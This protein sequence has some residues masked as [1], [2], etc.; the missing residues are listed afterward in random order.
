MS[1]EDNVEPRKVRRLVLLTG[2]FESQLLMP[3]LAKIADGLHVTHV[4]TRAALDAAMAKDLAGT[5]L[6]SFCTAVIVPGALLDRLPGPA[7][8]IHPGSPNY[9]GRH[10]ESWGAYDAVTR[11]GATLHE[12]VPR[13][14]EGAIVDVEWTDIP[15]GSG[16]MAVGLQAFRAAL[17]LFSRWALRLSEDSAPLPRSGAVWSGRKTTH[18]Q[19]V[20]MCRITAEIDAAEFERRRRAFAE[21]PGSRMSLMLH[22][23]EFAFVAPAQPMDGTAGKQTEG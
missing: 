9:P 17:R 22:G 20:D 23:R 7:Y 16:Q 14:D 6:L 5:R 19:L 15:A 21:Q 18:Q 10:P 4:E 1:A 13:V 12:M 3:H 11:F 8:N 2:A